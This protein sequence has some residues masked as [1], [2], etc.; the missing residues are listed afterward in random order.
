MLVCLH[1]DLS[2]TFICNR[3]ISLT[4]QTPRD[5]S[6]NSAA[7]NPWPILHDLKPILECLSESAC[8]AT[9][10]WANYRNKGHLNSTGTYPVS[11]KQL[12]LME[13][14]KSL[15]KSLNNIHHCLYISTF[16]YILVE[17]AAL[18]RDVI[19]QWAL[20]TSHQ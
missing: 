5:I 17:G 19:S 3:Y 8:P 6:S 13:K 16:P 4:L 12:V 2:I 9:L 10:Q 18:P 7:Q 11:R 1:L 20:S 14:K 15:T